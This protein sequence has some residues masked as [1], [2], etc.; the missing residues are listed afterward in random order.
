MIRFLDFVLRHD[1]SEQASRQVIWSG[2]TFSVSVSKILEFDSSS[3][4]Q[5]LAMAI[6]SL[7]NE[8]QAR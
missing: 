3:D 2:G 4:S 6:D 7:D 1:V 5:N 8:R